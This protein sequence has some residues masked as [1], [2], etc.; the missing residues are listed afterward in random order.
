MEETK[1]SFFDAL[2]KKG[3]FVFGIV[4]G[5]LVLCSIGF[6]ILLG[7]VLNSGDTASENPSI[8]AVKGPKKF[9]ECLDTGK[10]ADKIKADSALGS[11]LGV[12]GTPATFINGY[13]ISGAYPI[14]AVKQV[15]DRLL[16][17]GE[18]DFDFLKDDEG[19]IA[20][21]DM[22]E[23]PD[24]VWAG[25]KD[26]KVSLVT[27]SDFECPYCARFAPTVEQVLADYG[28][29]IRF[30]FRHYPLSFHTNAQKAA[31][32]YECAKEQGVN[33][34]MHDKLFELSDSKT[35]SVDNYKK[36]AT[37]LGLK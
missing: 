25:G 19:S 8:E 5:F 23:L 32:A 20:K 28:D 17:D 34:E 13:L 1:Q 31:E 18:P 6:F 35:M 16:S 24:V 22:P 12:Q 21:V 30:T 29:Q 11:S 26:A 36:A 3:S 9:S 7:V 27:F 15:I 33:M 4:G 10:Y 14:D 2:G 37:E